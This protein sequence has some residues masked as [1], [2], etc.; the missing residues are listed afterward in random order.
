MRTTITL[1]DDVAKMIE[2]LK[3]SEKK[4]FKQIVNELLRIGI[5]QKKSSLSGAGQQKQYSTP[6][7]EA[8]PCKYPDL[9]NIAE[10]LAVAEKEDFS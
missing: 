1:D 3:E 6:E 7:L 4:P 2:K 9:D 8:G 10:V 5:V